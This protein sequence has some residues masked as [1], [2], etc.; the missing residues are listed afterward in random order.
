ME[1]KPSTVSINGGSIDPHPHLVGHGIDE[2]F[3]LPRRLGWK[4][5]KLIL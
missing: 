4:P 5:T 2:A 1:V 3:S